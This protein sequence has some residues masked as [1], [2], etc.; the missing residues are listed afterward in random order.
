E[1]LK[2]GYPFGS[3]LIYKYSG[4][5]DEKYSIVDGLQR[6]STMV[7]FNESPHK[8][9]QDMNRFID[10]I[11]NE[12][13][14]DDIS[15]NTKRNYKRHV[16][17]GINELFEVSKEDRNYNTLYTIL[18]QD[19]LIRENVTP[20][21]EYIYQKQSDLVKHVNEYLDV[22]D[23]KI[24]CIEFT[25]DE[26]ELANVFQNLN[27]GGKKLSKYQVFSAQWSQYTTILNKSN[28]NAQVLS[29]VIDRYVS[30][31]D[32]RKVD[33]L[34]FDEAEMRAKSEINL[35]EF[36]YAFGKLIIGEMDVFW[37]DSDS[38]E[39]LAN[40]IGYS[41]LG[42]ILS[43][44]N[45]KLHE[46]PN[47]KEFFNSPDTIEVLIEKSL[48]IFR[49]INEHFKKYLKIP[50]RE[51]KYESRVATNFQILSYFASIWELKYEYIPDQGKV[52]EKQGY[53]TEV[54]KNFKNFIYYYIFDIVTSRWS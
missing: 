25:G 9:I 11:S 14:D 28:Y 12:I 15:E 48:Q 7:D 16:E 40:E 43:V 54:S 47:K 22:N 20:N 5:E 8:Y 53:K 13:I 2:R 18:S 26:T 39:D 1:T 50:G 4:Q 23:I 29:I 19:S 49:D 36:C 45:N 30:L 32:S 34:D 24:P 33:I 10:D 37:N 21:S 46:I 17:T 52:I 3:I 31:T 51:T 42:I 38:N 6:Y 35:S 44:S 27:R 41:T